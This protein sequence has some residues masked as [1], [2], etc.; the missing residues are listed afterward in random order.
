M[1]PNRFLNHIFFLTVSILTVFSGCQAQNLPF[2][3]AINKQGLKEVQLGNSNYYLL[4]PDNFEISE[5]RG[6][7]GQL[8]YNIM[9]KDTS[10]TMF[11]FIE[12]RHGHPI[13]G[14]LYDNLNSKAFAESLLANIRVQWKIATTETGYYQAY[15]SE[16]GDLNA[17]V[18]S[19]PRTD[20]DTLISIVASLKKK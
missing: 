10:L 11:G 14:N 5:A 9:P 4:L 20:I 1:K 3:S 12:I 15:T 2:I 13:G 16:N 6:K 18:S 17:R 7:E 19:K 8:G